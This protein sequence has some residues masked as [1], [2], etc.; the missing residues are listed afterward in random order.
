MCRQSLPCLI[1]RV[2][3]MDILVRI[4]KNISRSNLC[5][6]CGQFGLASFRRYPH[7]Y[8]LQG[9]LAADGWGGLESSVCPSPR[10]N[11]QSKIEKRIKQKGSCVGNYGKIK[12]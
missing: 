3:Y 10:I 8:Q 5:R 12:G 2:R 6:F 1:S 9:L 4:L 7:I 11:L